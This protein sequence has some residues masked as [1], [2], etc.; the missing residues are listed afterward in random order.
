MA[1]RARQGR[2]TSSQAAHP[3]ETP[4]NSQKIHNLSFS[5]KV[6]DYNEFVLVLNVYHEKISTVLTNTSVKFSKINFVIRT[7][8]S[9]CLMRLNLL[10]TDTRWEH[11]TKTSFWSILLFGMFHPKLFLSTFFFCIQAPLLVSLVGG[12]DPLFFTLEEINLPPYYRHI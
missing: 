9:I 2:R 11:F 8:R 1:W 10:E 12:T 7:R 4:H 3:G 6:S 5:F